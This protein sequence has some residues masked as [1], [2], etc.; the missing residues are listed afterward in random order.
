VTITLRMTTQVRAEQPKELDARKAGPGR[1]NKTGDNHHSFSSKERGNADYLT[2]RIARDRP[3]ILNKM[4]AG[5]YRNYRCIMA[6]FGRLR[7]RLFRL[8]HV[9]LRECSVAFNLGRLV[10]LMLCWR[11]LD[12]NKKSG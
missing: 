3:D 2:A 4:K 9:T 7:T 1:G 6:V 11:L 10:R 12:G 5:E 8:S